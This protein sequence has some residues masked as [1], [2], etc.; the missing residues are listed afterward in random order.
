[1]GIISFYPSEQDM[2]AAFGCASNFDSDRMVSKHVF[3]D[4]C[5]NEAIISFSVVDAS[6]RFTAMSSGIP[7]IEFYSEFANSIEIKDDSTL[8][9]EF[10]LG[11]IRQ[12]ANISVWPRWRINVNSLIA[13]DR[14]HSM[15]RTG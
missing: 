8:L 3:L 7:V 15:E 6:F 9:V 2:V 4:D 14:G 10:L 11:H 13:S 1:M 5:G 12:Y